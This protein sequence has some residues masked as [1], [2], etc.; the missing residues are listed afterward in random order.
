MSFTR[1]FITTRFIDYDQGKPGEP[2]SYSHQLSIAFRAVDEYTEAQ[3]DTPMRVR[4][5]GIPRSRALRNLS[6]HFC[7]EGLTPGNY[8]LVIEPDPLTAN[9]FF[10]KPLQGPWTDIFEIPIVVVANVLLNFALTLSPRP[11]YPFDPN[12][13]LVRGTVTQ[14]AP[15][16]ANAVVSSTYDQVN[17]QDTTQTVKK[18]VETLTNQDGEY[19]LFFKRLPLRTQ[20]VTVNAAKGGKQTQDSVLIT[21][22]TTRKALLLNLPL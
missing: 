4:L 3:L 20:Q 11:S 16:V 22:G 2:V 19:A 18:T 9:S 14:G 21:E 17:P 5:K 15:A 10:V 7:F 8:Q 12:A 1:P 13:T 6:G